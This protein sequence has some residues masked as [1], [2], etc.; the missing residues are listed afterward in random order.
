MCVIALIIPG[1]VISFLK[2]SRQNMDDH[3]L[4]VDET[5]RPPA[6]WTTWQLYALR[7]LAGYD[8]D[9]YKT[10]KNAVYSSAVNFSFMLVGAIAFALYF[11]FSAFTRPLLWAAMCGACLFP[12]KCTATAFVL[13]WLASLERKG[14]PLFVGVLLLPLQVVKSCADLVEYIAW[15][16]WKSLAC[17]CGVILMSVCCEYLAIWEVLNYLFHTMTYLAT[18]TL[19]IT[20]QR[21]IEVPVALL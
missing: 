8:E 20:E 18:V 17:L 2:K 6:K 14:R 15:S 3:F 5:T 19:D 4:S 10:V 11:V 13:D 7:K 21:R 16:Q 9:S 12:L 1:A